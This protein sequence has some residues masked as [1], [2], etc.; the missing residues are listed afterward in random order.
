M[1]SLRKEFVKITETACG[2]NYLSGLER[3]AA[4]S[5]QLHAF[6]MSGCP[7]DCFV[8]DLG[9]IFFGYGQVSFNELA[10]IDPPACLLLKNCI[11][12]WF[13]TQVW[14]TLFKRSPVQ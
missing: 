5:S 7:E 11:R 13:D 3:L 12:V 14:K 10:R 6:T 1:Q 2:N 4:I 9:A 8:E